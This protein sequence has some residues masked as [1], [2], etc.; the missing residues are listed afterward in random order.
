LIRMSAILSD[1]PERTGTFK[2]DKV[3]SAVIH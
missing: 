3:S 2:S 1:K